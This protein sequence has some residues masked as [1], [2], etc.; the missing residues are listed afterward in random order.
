M[1]KSRKLSPVGVTPCV[2]YLYYGLHSALES[3]IDRSV[4]LLTRRKRR[5]SGRMNWCLGVM[6]LVLLSVCRESCRS[7][8]NDGQLKGNSFASGMECNNEI[9]N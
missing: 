1:Y 9:S 2:Q 5:T 7:P 3:D 6:G 8:T 4:T